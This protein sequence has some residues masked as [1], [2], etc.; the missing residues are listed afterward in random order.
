MVRSGN[1]GLK[2]IGSSY[3]SLSKYRQKL[4]VTCSAAEHTP[5]ECAPGPPPVS[6]QIQSPRPANAREMTSLYSTSSVGLEES[7]TDQ[8]GT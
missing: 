7:D 6:Q 1:L 2:Y 3:T 5:A 8:H 4:S